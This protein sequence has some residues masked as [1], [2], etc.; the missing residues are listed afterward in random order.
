MITMNRKLKYCSIFLIITTL[1]ILSTS[2]VS[3]SEVDDNNYEIENNPMINSVDDNIDSVIQTTDNNNYEK[4]KTIKDTQIDTKSYKELTK[5]NKNIKKANIAATLTINTSE[6]SPGDVI[7]LKLFHTAQISTSYEYSYNVTI[8]NVVYQSGTA[9]PP[10][11]RNLYVN[12]TVP[13][14]EAGEHTLT[15]NAYRSK[16]MNLTGSQPL[17]IISGTPTLKIENSSTVEG[18]MDDFTLPVNIQDNDGNPIDI[19]SSITIS[20]GDTV[21][22]ENYPITQ[23]NNNISIPVTR[24][25]EYPLTVTV[26]QTPEYSTSTGQINVKVNPV[27]TIL[28]VDD[29]EDMINCSINVVFNTVLTGS[30]T[31]VNGNPV[32][33]TEITITVDGQDD[34]VLTDDEG[35]YSYQYPVTELMSDIPIT[36]SFNG[37]EGYNQAQDI[38]GTFN[39]VPIDLIVTFDEITSEVNETTTISGTLKDSD[40]IPLDNV[41]FNLT[42]STL[43]DNVVITSTNGSF[44][45]DHIFTQTGIVGL[46]ASHDLS[47]GLYEMEATTTEFTTI[48]G[49]IRTNLTVDVGEGQDYYIEYSDVTPFR[50]STITTGRLVDKFGENVANAQI[51][52]VINNEFIPTITD[53]EGNFQVVYNAT[54]PLST[55][56]ISIKF[57][58]NDNYMAAQEEY[59]GI[60]TTGEIELHVYLD[61]NLNSEYLIQENMT[62]TGYAILV[63]APLK[64]S[65]VALTI[66]NT[67]Y[68]ITTDENGHFT[69]T[70]TPTHEGL[71]T[72][73]T[74]DSILS[75]NVVKPEVSVIFDA[76]SDM[77]ALV[78]NTINGRLFINTNSTGISGSVI[79]TINNEEYTIQTNEDGTFTYPFTPNIIGLNNISVTF[80][81]PQYTTTANDSTSFN[82]E[83][84]KTAVNSDDLPIA[85]SIYDDYIISGTLVDENNNPIPNA[86]ISIKI[87]DEE[88]STLTDDEGMYSYN[89]PTSVVKDNNLY[90][91][92]YYGNEYYDLARN[93]VGSF[94]D[95]ETKQVYVNVDVNDTS[96][97]TTTKIVGF[98]KDARNNGLSTDIIIN[99]DDESYTTSSDENGRYEYDYTPRKLGKHDVSVI[100]DNE[101]Y[102]SYKVESS[103]TVDKI[104][105]IIAVNPVKATSIEK[106]NLIANVTDANNNPISGGKVVFKVNG[107]TV[108]DENGKIL[109]ANVENGLASVEYL[110][111]ANQIEMH[112]NITA[113]YSG[114]TSYNS[115]RSLAVNVVKDEQNSKVN[116]SIN[117]ITA[118][119]TESITLT[120]TVKN[121]NNNPINSGKVIFKINGKSIKDET[122]KVI[123]STVINGSA[124][125]D[126]TISENMKNK[127]YTLTAVYSDPS[128]DR[129]EAQAILT[130]IKAEYIIIN[131]TN[132]TPISDN[133]INNSINTNNIPRNTIKTQSTIIINNDTINNYFTN[134]GLTELVQ[135]GDILDFQGTISDVSGLQSIIIDKPVNIITTT[136]DGRIER[137]TNI[138]YTNSASGSN[139]TGLYT[140]NTQFYV[141]NANHIIFDNISNVVNSSSI[142]WGVGQT[143]IREDSSYITLKNSFIYTKDNG[144]SSSFVL[145]YASHNTIINNTIMAEGNV[146]NL[147]YFNIV[148]AGAQTSVG[149]SYNV[150]ANNSLI[151]PNPPLVICYALQLAAASN[152]II[153]NNTFNYSGRALG[154]SSSDSLIRY[155]TFYGGEIQV[156]GA[157]ITDNIMYNNG[158]ITVYKTGMVENNTI[159]GIMIMN[160]ESIV[161]NNVVDG[162]IMGNN[163]TVSN[164]TIN[165]DV[166]YKD[167]REIVSNSLLENC[168]I[169]GNILV[170]TN[171]RTSYGENNIIQNN[172]ITG[173]LTLNM[174]RRLVINNNN[175]NG[176]ILNKDKSFNTTISN[177]N[178]T[179]E[180]EYTITNDHSSTVIR[181]NTLYSADKVGIQTINDNT[182]NATIINNKPIY[183]INITMDTYSDFF[184]DEG[185]FYYNLD[186]ESD[187]MLHGEFDNV[188]M[189]FTGGS[190]RLVGYDENCILNNCILIISD[191]AKLNVENITFKQSNANT[192]DQTSIKVESNDNIINQVNIISTE[193]ICSNTATIVVSGTNNTVINSKVNITIENCDTSAITLIDGENIVIT[194]NTIN[195]VGENTISIINT[196]N[197]QITYNYLLSSRGIKEDSVFVDDDSENILLE[198][199]SPDKIIVE[200]SGADI[201]GVVL[202]NLD[203]TITLIDTITQTNINEGYIYIMV[204]DEL[205]EDEYGN[206][207][208][209]N[210]VDSKAFIDSQIIPSGWLRSDTNITI[211]YSG[212]I[213]Y[214]P[215]NITVI[216]EI[217]KRDATVEI[218]TEDIATA[219]G[220]TITLQAKITD[221][222]S[223]VTDGKVAFKLNGNSLTDDDG[224]LICVDV[225]D[226]IATLEYTLPESIGQDSYELTAVFKNMLYNRSTDTSTLT[227][228]E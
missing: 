220:S 3:A 45:Y 213:I 105:T 203:T 57:D 191:D 117:N 199:N 149:N 46:T 185:I 78:E 208:S 19:E 121:M 225:I 10:E 17:T 124:T 227:I 65:E 38:H 152:N 80:N 186:N 1:I 222:D 102:T 169:N 56:N 97:N 123:Y 195:V 148:N 159:H 107:I 85:V 49:P 51:S 58:G 219:S 201:T 212:S 100:V 226:G 54:I 34:V 156:S 114:S 120:A 116:L 28:V 198:N 29:N 61:N 5:D 200:I 30:L 202:D 18:Y 183:A 158:N 64:N 138:T 69:Y 87:N 40:G 75:I 157:N 101:I 88:F 131:D 137:F 130:V 217:Q 37:K 206:L 184:N 155:N 112:A 24:V 35:K 108:K 33:N 193:T 44:S 48:I 22:I 190:Y 6:A 180:G 129:A 99:V 104:N 67:N 135:E 77:K 62:I 52:V 170:T 93:Y 144:G 20:D 171:S 11:N 187:I 23:A 106:A 113:V 39:I 13:N 136:N 216:P 194:N 8:D 210:V 15:M 41:T 7:E 182:H 118:A 133:P 223:L 211:L 221:G 83:K 119:A 73:N 132:T 215:I 21:L 209:F 165:G 214:S 122:G 74:T 146:G 91:V 63:D 95:V 168:T 81:S 71:I 142:G 14:I 127:D 134:D 153:E 68:I 181:D 207:I 145:T 31:T 42:I 224:N 12:F 143:S 218:L 150:I 140:Y 188:I 86:N 72:A 192:F 179:S 178:I 176:S 125:A 92:R 47:S 70:Y 27:N 26:S 9:R 139:V 166:T 141:V 90:E 59:S 43:S 103:F 32:K 110:F 205:L 50:N 89:Y 111:S 25:G 228:T 94:F 173:N 16:A 36:V 84:L 60:F 55:Y 128:Y 161:K 160:K 147:I 66:D 163:V 82:V 189:K 126:Y 53:S 162:L 175:I 154:G 98:V 151:G 96:I 79:L 4:E 177:N 115:S 174:S 172:N 164:L 76:V 197:S 196:K 109:Y 2:I 204:N 167:S